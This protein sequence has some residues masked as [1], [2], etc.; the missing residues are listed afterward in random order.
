MRPE[1]VIE[2]ASAGM[3]HG[4]ILRQA[5]FKGIREDKAAAEVVPEEP[6]PMKNLA[7][8]PAPAPSKNSRPRTRAR[9]KMREA[10][11]VRLTH[12]DRVY[13]ADVGVTKKDLA[14]Y[15][16]SVWDW[17]KPH[18]VGRALAIVRCPDGT[19]ASASFRSTS[20]R[21]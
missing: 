5:S 20:P 18:L 16:V 3:T 14:D 7:K 6:A 2:A 9:T 21:T 11:K 12:P 19:A 10:P 13:W 17:M 15:Y 8:D 1:L 4:G